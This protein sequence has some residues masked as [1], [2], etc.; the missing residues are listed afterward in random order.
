LSCRDFFY[1]KTTNT[2]TASGQNSQQT[3]TQQ[4]QITGTIFDELG[5]TMVGVT[6]R[7]KDSKSATITD[8]NGQFTVDASLFTFRLERYEGITKGSRRI[9]LLFDGAKIGSFFEV[10]KSC[11]GFWRELSRI[12]KNLTV[13]QSY[14][15][16][17]Y[18]QKYGHRIL[19]YKYINIFSS[20]LGG[21]VLTV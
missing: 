17:N 14:G 20:I 1:Y 7:V 13:L 6:I 15:V 4:S 3:V 19:I 8:L 21:A 18:G 11:P 9:A 2:P 12:L 5:E 16:R 10:N